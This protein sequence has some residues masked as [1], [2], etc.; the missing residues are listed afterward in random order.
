MSQLENLRQILDGSTLSVKDKDMWYQ[1]LPSLNE[2][3]IGAL[4]LVLKAN[5]E[6]VSYLHE[7]LLRK[8]L[9]L[10]ANDWNEWEKLYKEE[11]KL[12]EDLAKVTK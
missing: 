4:Y 12:I 8:I 1:V 9:I 11:E 6:L 10:Q 2:D 3:Q 5:P 7:N